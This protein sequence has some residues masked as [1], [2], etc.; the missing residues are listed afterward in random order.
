MNN[1]VVETIVGAL[2]V[3]C[4]AGFLFYAYQHGGRVSPPG[5]EITAKFDRIDGLR[6]GSDVRLGGIKIGSVVKQELD[7]QTYMAVVTLKINHG[8]KLPK[9]SSAQ[10]SM[11]GL[12]G[13]NYLSVQPGADETMLSQGEEISHT[14]GAVDLLSLMGKMIFSQTERRPGSNSTDG[15]K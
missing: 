13:E 15:K 14:Q 5:Y 10:V 7:P 12:L 2:V 9:D 6:E 3:F 1:R 4:A 8:I 11:V